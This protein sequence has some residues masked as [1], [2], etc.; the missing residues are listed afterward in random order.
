MRVCANTWVVGVCKVGE[1]VEL[2]DAQA[3]DFIARGIAYPVDVDAA[4]AAPPKQDTAHAAPPE[5]IEPT[6]KRRK[7]K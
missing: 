6:P 7:R 1:T 5:Q 4:Q 2:P 3:R